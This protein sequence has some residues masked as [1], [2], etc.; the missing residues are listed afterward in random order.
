MEP[1]LDML[2]LW[3]PDLIEGVGLYH[4][5]LHVINDK[6]RDVIILLLVIRVAIAI[7][8]ILHGANHSEKLIRG[9]QHLV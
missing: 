3:H 4:L 1:L 6:I 2:I 8:R 9:L 5:L 7:G